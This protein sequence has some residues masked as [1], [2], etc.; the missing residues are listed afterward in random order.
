MATKKYTTS[1]SNKGVIAARIAPMYEL[2]AGTAVPTLTVDEIRIELPSPDLSSSVF[3]AW[4]EFILERLMKNEHWIRH[5]GK[6]ILIGFDEYQTTMTMINSNAIGLAD[7][8]II[9]FMTDNGF[10]LLYDTFP[11]PTFKPLSPCKIPSAIVWKNQAPC[12]LR[13]VSVIKS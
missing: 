9:E 2:T 6:W 12:M 7:E 4:K 13:I 11:V 8:I 1:N 10:K 5:F 3:V